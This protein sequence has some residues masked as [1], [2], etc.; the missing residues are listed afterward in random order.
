[1]RQ[2]FNNIHTPSSSGFMPAAP[3]APALSSFMPAAPTALASSSFVP[4]APTAPDIPQ[5]IRDK[6]KSGHGHAKIRAQL[7]RV[8][9][10]DHVAVQAKQAE[11]LQI[12]QVV[13]D[14]MNPHTR[15]HREGVLF[16]W[17]LTL[18]SIA[19]DLP[20]EL[21]WSPE[22]IMK[23]ARFYLRWRVSDFDIDSLECKFKLHYLNS[24]VD[25]TPG[26]RAP[27]VKATTVLSWL[28]HFIYCIVKYTRDPVT[29]SSQGVQVLVKGGLF[30]QLEQ[31][32]AQ[33]TNIYVHRILIA[34]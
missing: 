22:V 5:A 7:S 23:Y 29:K 30:T 4:A 16:T 14:R 32:A 33:S 11:L 13:L 1:M 20:D 27:H 10:E 2:D 25:C 17:G 8:D 26:R 12:S 9:A 28:T 21:H 34:D 19:P 3:T 24:K 18:Q 6:L 15:R 31:E